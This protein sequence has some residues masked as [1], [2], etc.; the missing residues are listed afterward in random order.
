MDMKT[1]TRCNIEKELEDFSKQST[2]K[3]GYRS[4]CKACISIGSKQYHIKNKEKI[5]NYQKKYYE[6]NLEKIKLYKNLYREENK[7]KISNERKKAYS[8]NKEEIDSKNRE[9][10]Y[11]NKTRRIEYAR[12]YS[13]ER[14]SKDIKF[15]L[16]SRISTAIYQHL[17]RSSLSKKETGWEKAVG[18]G[19]K[20]LMQHLENQFD[21]NM[22]WENYG[23]YWH[24]D[25]IKPKS[26]FIFESV[27][28]PQ[29][30]ECWSLE[31]LRPL[32]AKENI[33]KGNKYANM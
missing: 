18:Y 2:S 22:S 12:K 11:K 26:L 21:T 1:C 15:K 3:D 19:V 24:I 32:E 9:S 7:E 28:D 27:E 14:K 13:K 17:K 8:L 10:Y 20:E 33:R 25:H 4:A 31:N 29:F 5:L 16:N 23:S 30:K 6:S